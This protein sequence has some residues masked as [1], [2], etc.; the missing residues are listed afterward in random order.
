[1]SGEQRSPAVSDLLTTWGGEGEMIK[2]PVS[3]QELRRKI[4]LKAKSEKAW[5]F[6]QGTAVVSAGTGGI[7]TGSIRTLGYIMTTRSDIIRPESAARL[8]GRI[9]L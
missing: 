4:Y 7:G 9:N 5:R 6:R 2:A 3:L 1:M 8:V